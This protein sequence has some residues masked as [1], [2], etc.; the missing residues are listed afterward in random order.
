M[1]FLCFA[2]K[3]RLRKRRTSEDRS[4]NSSEDTRAHMKLP[5]QALQDPPTKKQHFQ[6]SS[7]LPDVLTASSDVTNAA[8][9]FPR[10][11]VTPL[12]GPD[13][14]GYED[15]IRD[16]NG[17]EDPIRDS[18]GYKDTV[19]D[20]HCANQEPLYSEIQDGEDNCTEVI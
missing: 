10:H 16:S 3:Q 15:P 7:S 1:N 13:S 14:D 9:L 11:Y 2:L 4:E 6:P 20:A 17:Y 12:P 8:I 19:Y 18:D 5:C